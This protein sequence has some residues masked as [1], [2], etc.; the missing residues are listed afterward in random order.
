MAQNLKGVLHSTQSSTTYTGS[1]CVLG[2]SRH[3]WQ[4]FKCYCSEM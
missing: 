1:G 4:R 2:I 3:T